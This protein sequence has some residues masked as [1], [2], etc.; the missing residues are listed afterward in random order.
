MGSYI[1][2]WVE[3]VGRGGFE[4]DGGRG[5][6][7]V[8][9]RHS[10]YPWIFTL[11]FLTLIKNVLTFFMIFSSSSSLSFSGKLHL[12]LLDFTLG[13]LEGNRGNNNKVSLFLRRMFFF[14]WGFTTSVGHIT[15][16]TLRPKNLNVR[17][18]LL[19]FIRVKRPKNGANSVKSPI[20]A[21]CDCSC[22]VVRVSAAQGRHSLR[23]HPL[24][25]S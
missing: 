21:L 9:L 17:I 7:P 3:H 6:L 4:G 12:K 24:K 10:K 1:Y 8:R 25:P 23:I 19:R 16:T 22:S 20:T 2:S 14:S 11:Q 15:L 18:P 5:P 13:P